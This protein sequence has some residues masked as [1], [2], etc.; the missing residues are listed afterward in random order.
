MVVVKKPQT[1]EVEDVLMVYEADLICVIADQISGLPL[2]KEEKVRLLRGVVE[3][4]EDI[5]GDIES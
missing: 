2:T 3:V 1:A 5:I 4:I